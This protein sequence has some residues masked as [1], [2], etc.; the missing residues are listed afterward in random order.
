M[1]F[2]LENALKPGSRLAEFHILEVLG[3]GGFGITYKAYDEHLDDTVAIKEFFPAEYAVRRDDNATVKAR[4]N[5]D[6]DYF[7]YGL[8][9]FRKEAKT[10]ARFAEHPNIVTVRRYLE[11]HETAYLVMHY[12]EGQTLAQWLRAYPQP[13]EEDLRDIFIPVLDGLREVHNRNYLH[14]DIKPGNIYIRNDGRPMLIDFGS[15]RQALGDRSH[16]L[17]II[18]SEGYAA[19][20]Q[21]SRKGN[22]GPWTD[23]YG[24]GAT[25]WRAISGQDPASAADRSEARDEGQPDPLRPATEIGQGRYSENLLQAIDWA[26]A[27]LPAERPQTV[28][29][30]QKKLLSTTHPVTRP[31]PEPDPELPKAVSEKPDAL[32]KRIQKTLLWLVLLGIPLFIAINKLDLHPSPSTSS[33]QSPPQPLLINDRYRD[34]GGGTVTDIKTNLQWMRCALGQ[35]WKDGSCEGEAAEYPW[36]QALD[37]AKA[38]SYAGYRDWRVPSREELTSLVYCS[39][40]RY[41]VRDKGTGE[42]EC[43]GEYSKPTIDTTAF[44]NTPA[45]DFWSASP[46]ASFA[47]YAWYVYFYYGYDGWHNRSSANHVRLVRAGQ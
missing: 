3:A 8:E 43:K 32:E 18:L 33:Y 30:F 27:Y 38:F 22:Q 47:D 12:E 13:T 34:N 26:L 10:L 16:S 4:S 15:A 36:Q 9:A 29:E 6:W 1:K 11:A 28:R 45:S 20:E 2:E 5:K 14:R 21:Y 39:S 44:P 35:I 41:E 24:I 40:G 17:S 31:E 37:A 7:Q 46:L 19:K 25:L 23:V 42:R